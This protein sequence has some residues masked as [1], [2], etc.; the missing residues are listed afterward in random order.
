M[1]R[2]ALLFALAALAGCHLADSPDAVQC[3]P[4]QHP[5]D[6][7]CVLDDAV[8]VRVTIQPGDAGG[9]CSV[10]AASIKVA[11]NGNFEFLNSDTVD[12]VIAGADGQ[13]WT[14]V[15]AGLLSPLVAITKAGT[16]PYTVSGCAMGGT[17]V[18][19]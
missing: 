10:S 6:G 3:E 8:A 15:K 12:H 18:V 13:T 11:P 16:W 7:H 5:S 1:T 19:E 17:V 4:G 9:S 2:A 14:T